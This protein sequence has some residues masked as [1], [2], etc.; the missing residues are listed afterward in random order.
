MLAEGER[1]RQVGQ[2]GDECWQLE[3]AIQMEFNAILIELH[4]NVF[5]A[6]SLTLNLSLTLLRIQSCFASVFVFVAC[7]SS[8]FAVRIQLSYLW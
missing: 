2:T 5:A 8:I 7:A 3:K 6:L 1:G 4:C